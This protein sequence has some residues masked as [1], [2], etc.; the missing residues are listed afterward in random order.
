MCQ[1][2]APALPYIRL[3]IGS[4]VRTGDRDSNATIPE[5]HGAARPACNPTGAVFV[6]SVPPYVIDCCVKPEPTNVGSL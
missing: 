4:A 6:V 3:G 1:D 5:P 2:A